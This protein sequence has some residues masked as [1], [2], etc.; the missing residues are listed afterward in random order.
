VTI[1]GTI[2]NTIANEIPT[3]QI[4]YGTG[5]PPA[6]GASGNTGTLLGGYAG[7]TGNI[8]NNSSPFSLSGVVTGAALGVPIWFDLQLWNL[9]AGGAAYVA[10]V[11]V[12][13]VELP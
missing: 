5:T 7:L 12:T 3:C 9:S 13:A 6:F 11:S 1:A 8:V 2:V 10:G 4:R